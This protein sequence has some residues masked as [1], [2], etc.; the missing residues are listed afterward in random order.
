MS[1]MTLEKLIAEG[2]RIQ[3]PCNLLKP[4]GTGKPV[5]MWFEP[6]AD[7]ESIT[8]WRRWITVRAD[9]LPD[10]K[11]GNLF[12][13]SVYTKGSSSGL[14]DFVDRWPPRSGIPLYAH[15]ASIMPPIDAVFALGS[16]EIGEWLAV[17]DWTR[18]RRYS[19]GFPD[20]ALVQEYEKIWFAE[21]P[22]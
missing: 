16:A 10:F 8:D 13:F 4:M 9:A 3:R 11:S 22:I 2:R 21:N 5:A 12:F 7:D 19:S 6:D 14:I 18:N 17:N 20:R 1:K 15:A